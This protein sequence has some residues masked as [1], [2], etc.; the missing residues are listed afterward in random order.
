MTSATSLG[1]AVVAAAAAAASANGANGADKAGQNGLKAEYKPEQLASLLA[2]ATSQPLVT[3]GLTSQTANAAPLTVSTTTGGG[4]FPNLNGTTLYRQ[5]FGQT[6]A[7]GGFP[8]AAALLQN[9][10]PATLQNGTLDLCQTIAVI[11]IKTI[12]FNRPHHGLD[13]Q[14]AAFAEPQ[15][16]RDRDFSCAS[17]GDRLP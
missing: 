12:C 7:N 4:L 3:G 5:S 16:E 8:P 11:C 6:A 15:A 13:L 10:S 1:P 2:A 17:A 14:E 9:Q